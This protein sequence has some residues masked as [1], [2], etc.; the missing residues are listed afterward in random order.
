MKLKYTI[1]SNRHLSDYSG[2]PKVKTYL[3]Y[4]DL[5]VDITNEA[6]AIPGS[7]DDKVAF[8]YSFEVARFVEHSVTIGEK[9]TANEI[10]IITE[11]ARGERFSVVRVDV[12]K[13]ERLQVTELPS[14]VGAYKFFPKP[15]LHTLFAA[16]GLRTIEGQ[17]DLPYEGSLNQIFSHIE[18]TSV[19]ELIDQARKV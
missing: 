17:F 12:N 6:A 19:K 9:V 2:C 14:H 7:G 4:A 10:I 16:I 15:I 1:V 13:L 3:K 11:E 18:L 5:L 8:T